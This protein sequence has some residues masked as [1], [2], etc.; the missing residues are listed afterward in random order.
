MMFKNYYCF[1]GFLKIAILILVTLSSKVFIDGCIVPNVDQN[2]VEVKCY[3]IQTVTTGVSR[4]GSAA[5]SKLVEDSCF[6]DV[7][8]IVIRCKIGFE[9]K[10]SKG[11]DA[12]LN[13]CKNGKWKYENTT[14]D[15]CE[16]ICGKLFK[17][18]LKPTTTP[19]LYK[20]NEVDIRVAPWHVAVYKNNSYKFDQICGGTI[21]HSNI[22][23]SAAHCFYDEAYGKL[24]DSS[25]F[26]IGAGKRYRQYEAE[27]QLSQ[28]ARINHIYLPPTFQAQ[29]LRSDIA[30]LKLDRHFT[31]SPVIAPVCLD[32]NLNL[33]YGSYNGI[34]GHLYGW[35]D[36]S[37]KGVPSEKLLKLDLITIPNDYCRDKIDRNFR[38]DVSGDRF[39]AINEENGTACGGD[40]G[41]GLITYRQGYKLSGVVSAG[42]N[43]NNYCTDGFVT[44]F[45]NV[46]IFQDFLKTVVS[47]SRDEEQDLE[48]FLSLY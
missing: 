18:E 31:Y 5:V 44:L 29:P 3:T 28:F 8:A 34:I 30:A 41:S 12:V 6:Q 11:E 20:G 38:S 25:N 27:E 19:L 46:R 42:L 17:E 35:G 9:N 47:N 23:V 45:T 16:S 43:R 22:V 1:I 14:S 36:T 39:C 21:I 7:G 26:W 32:W 10:N 2:K 40:S 13:T 37:S 24:Y 48:T 4:A 15:D 33:I